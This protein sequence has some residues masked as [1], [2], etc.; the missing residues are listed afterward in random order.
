MQQLILNEIAF[1]AVTFGTANL[2]AQFLMRRVR[3]AS[4]T[5]KET[6]WHGPVSDGDC[7]NQIE[8]NNL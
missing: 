4:R 7:K 6:L 5:E 2:Q 8:I 1:D 3:E